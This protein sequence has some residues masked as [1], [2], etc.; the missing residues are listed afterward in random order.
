[1]TTP[2]KAKA[3]HVLSTSDDADAR[4]LAA[5]VLGDADAARVP[6]RSADELRDLLSKIEGVEGQH[7][8]AAEVRRQLEV[9]GG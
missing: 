7:E 2:I 5:Y 6:D 3:G 4:S 8:R 1:M 9:L